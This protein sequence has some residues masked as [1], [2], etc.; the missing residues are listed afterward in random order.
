MMFFQP[1]SAYLDQSIHL[2][3]YR[4]SNESFGSFQE[5]LYSTLIKEESFFPIILNDVSAL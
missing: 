5:E 2:H 1:L 4:T 3:I